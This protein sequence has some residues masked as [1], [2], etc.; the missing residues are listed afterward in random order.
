MSNERF[1]C[2]RLRHWED[3][4]F[5]SRNR[6]FAGTLLRFSILFSLCEIVEIFIQSERPVIMNEIKL[7]TDTD[8][9]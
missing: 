4:W 5:G 9:E 7:K 1:G 6:L 2:H 3:A 8:V